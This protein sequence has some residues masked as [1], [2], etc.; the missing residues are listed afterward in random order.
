MGWCG[1]NWSGSGL[2]QVE[3]CCKCVTKPSGSIKFWEVLEWLHNWLSLQE[4]LNSLVLV[5]FCTPAHSYCTD[6]F[7]LSSTEV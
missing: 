6:S 5:H 1:L 4:G 7:K 2:E 3:S